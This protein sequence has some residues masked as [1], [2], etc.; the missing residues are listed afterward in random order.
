M[1]KLSMLS[2][3]ALIAATLACQAVFP[4]RPPTGTSDLGCNEIIAAVGELRSN[5]EFPE[6]FW[7]ENPAGLRFFFGAQQ[8]PQ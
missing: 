2:I 5:L 3:V 8:D 1:N 4:T 7:Q 6:Y